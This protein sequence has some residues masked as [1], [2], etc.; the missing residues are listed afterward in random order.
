MRPELLVDEKVRGRQQN[1]TRWVRAWIASFQ[2]SS[3]LPANAVSSSK[4]AL[5]MNW[6]SGNRTDLLESIA[7][8]K[9]ERTSSVV[10]GL[11][12]AK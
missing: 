9:N 3:R 2:L 11:L 5:G 10:A 12:T 1:F 4:H 6:Q 7:S 8:A